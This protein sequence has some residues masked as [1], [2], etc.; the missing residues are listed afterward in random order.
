MVYEVNFLNL[1]DH[2]FL[3]IKNLILQI[4]FLS[5]TSL[6]QVD[7]LYSWDLE[8]KGRRTFYFFSI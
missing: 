2:L 7:S 1:K 3:Q 6:Q 8:Y 4:I 5:L